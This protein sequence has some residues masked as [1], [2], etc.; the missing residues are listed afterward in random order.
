MKILSM[1]A[2]FGKLSHQS[3]TLEPGLNVI[4]APNEWGK[5]TWCAFLVAMLYGIDTRER[6]SSATLADKEHYAPWSGE[7]MSGRMDLYWNGRNITVE[8]G[9]KGRVPFGTFRAYETESGLP[10]TELTAANCGEVLLGVE[11]SVFAKTGFIRLSDMPVTQDE[12][13]RRRLNTL[14]TTG[15]ESDTG[16]VLAQKLRDLRNKCRHNKT[17]LLP[18]AEAQ[19]DE[20]LRKLDQHDLLQAQLD[21]IHT[22]KLEL[23][24]QLKALENHRQALEYEAAQKSNSRLEQVQAAQADAQRKWEELSAR[25]R[26]LPTEALALSQLQQLRSLKTQQLAL[27]AEVMPA[28][29]QQPQ[30]PEV[31]A[32]MSPGEALKKA[33]DDKAAFEKLQNPLLWILPILFGIFTAAGIVLA[34]VRWYLLFPGLFLGALFLA[35]YLRNKSDRNR[36]QQSFENRYGTL[37]PEQWVCL[38][39]EYSQQMQA[40]SQ[41]SASAKALS[42]SFESRRQMLRSSIHALTQGAALE[43]AIARW[44]EVANEHSAL[45]KAQ[46]VLQQA[47]DRAADLSTAVKVVKPP[48]SPDSLTLSPAETTAAI[49]SAHAKLNQLQTQAGQCVGQK[50]TLGTRETLQ[51]S[52]S[53]ITAR[54][55]RLEDTYSGLTIAMETLADATNELQ[56]RFAPK[57]ASRAQELFSKFTGGRYDRL[58]LTQDLGLNAGAVGEDGLQ[59]A[60]WRSDGTVDQLYLALRLAVA[61][62][63]TPNAPLVLDD[64]LVRFDDTRLAA[65]MEILREEAHSRQVILFTCQNREQA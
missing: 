15:D 47:N 42:D 32:G 52:L 29:P 55:D 11:K 65:A 36:R 21:A 64:A 10:V 13:L 3:L 41:K 48:E 19:R 31:F 22:A 53:S 7:P 58:Q 27:D 49:D 60:R 54:I 20:I 8:R 37:S 18:Q 50:Q 23:T 35:L 34:F 44:E 2:T 39:Q 46:E 63:L 38:A 30:A 56:R 25:C 61:G 4:H 57:I 40:F 24:A 62:E 51:Q 1:T 9:T 14:V 28:P 12:A 59:S 26:L 43:E 5:S 17:G 6:S 33:E 45:A 16:D